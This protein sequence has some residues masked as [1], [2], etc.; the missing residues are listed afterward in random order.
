MRQRRGKTTW[1]LN[2]KGVGHFQGMH[3]I[4]YPLHPNLQIR[5]MYEMHRGAHYF[6]V[7]TITSGVCA[8]ILSKVETPA[9]GV[10]VK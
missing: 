1:N 3:H 5:Y 6:T 9:C 10:A 2:S 7:L 8:G 4:P